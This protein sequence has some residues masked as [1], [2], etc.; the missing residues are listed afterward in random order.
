MPKYNLQPFI[1]KKMK[2]HI[3]TNALAAAAFL[4]AAPL[5]L[6]AETYYFDTN[7]L[8]SLGYSSDIMF[9]QSLSIENGGSTVYLW[10]TKSEDG[11]KTY[12][13]ELPNLSET[14]SQGNPLHSISF[15]ES[16]AG[17][18][19]TLFFDTD[20]NVARIDNYATNFVPKMQSEEYSASVGTISGHSYYT[21]FYGNATNLVVGDIDN[22]SGCVTVLGDTS[23]PLKSLRVTGTWNIMSNGGGARSCLYVTDTENHGIDNPDAVINRVYASTS[24]QSDALLSYGICYTSLTAAINADS[25]TWFNSFEGTAGIVVSGSESSTGTLTAVFTNSISA[26]S[27]GSLWEGDRTFNRNENGGGKLALVMRS[28]TQ[29]ETGEYVYLNNTQTFGGDYMGFSGG[30]DMISGGLFLNY[31]ATGADRT[32]G[33]LK[34]RKAEGAQAAVFGNSAAEVGGTFVFTDLEVSDGGGSIRVR[35]DLNDNLDLIFDSISLTGAAAGSGEV[36]ISFANA[37]GQSPEDYLAFLIA[38]SAQEGIKVISWAQAASSDIIFTTDDEYATIMHDGVEY[39]FS[40]YNG[41]DGLYVAYVVPE[42]AEWAA[43]FGILALAAA[44]LR[45]RGR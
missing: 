9:S 7:T 39:M 34:L 36:K 8:S 11:A 20:I 24:K 33:N 4:S 41:A 45:R 17:F 26:S 38:E 15:G 30:V 40:A 43:A 2:L 25:Y 12:L 32:H 44:A 10:Y 19:R 3:S 1:A 18:S 21:G 23:R 13:T 42:P 27:N 37:L 5:F 14:G 31:S 22:A 29:T 28:S 35:L 16:Q 6:A